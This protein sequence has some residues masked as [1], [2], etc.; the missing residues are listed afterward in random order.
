[1]SDT[2]AD[3][4]LDGDEMA[5]LRRGVQAFN[6]GRFFESHDLLEEAWRGMRGEARPFFKGL[7]QAAVG[8]YHAEDGNR[9]GA[10]SQL[11]QALAALAECPGRYLGLDVAALR[12]GV[13][14]LLADVEAGR[15]PRAM[16]RCLEA[17]AP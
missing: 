11:G 14:A 4:T 8:C 7:I 17:P 13:A 5:L 16:P 6:G 9:R 10:E 15:P 2:P 1:M 3:G 12:E